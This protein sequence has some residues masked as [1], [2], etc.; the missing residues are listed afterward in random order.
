MPEKTTNPVKIVVDNDVLEKLDKIAS[1]IRKDIRS[2]RLPSRGRGP[3]IGVSNVAADIVRR[4]V[5]EHP[6]LL[7]EFFEDETAVATS[8][9]APKERTGRRR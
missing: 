6:E 8:E 2:G 3:A 5:R 1:E 9:Q 7:K 4:I